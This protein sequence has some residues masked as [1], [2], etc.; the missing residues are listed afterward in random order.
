MNIGRQFCEALT[1]AENTKKPIYLIQS[2]DDETVTLQPCG[3]CNE[4]YFVRA[5]VFPPTTKNGRLY[6]QCRV[7]SDNAPA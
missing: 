6:D 1:Q 5:I 3:L 7:Y 2:K 4:D